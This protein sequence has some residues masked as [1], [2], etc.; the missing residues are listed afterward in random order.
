MLLVIK[1]RTLWGQ[2]DTRNTLLNAL[3]EHGYG[4]EQLEEIM[5][6]INADNSDIY[7][8]LAYIAYATPPVTREERVASYY[9]RTDDQHD[10]KLQGFLNFV[11]K[12]YVKEG[13]GE[14]DTAKLSKLVK[15]KYYSVADAETQLGNMSAIRTAF[16]QFQVH[17]YG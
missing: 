8:V 17:L 4:K 10:E 12:Q 7:D 3:Q 6:I 15:A 13:V 2:P 11:L 1:K 9:Q 5:P 16:T 14:L